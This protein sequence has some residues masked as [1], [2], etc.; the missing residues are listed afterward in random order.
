[1]EQSAP[2]TRD[3]QPVHVNHQGHRLY[4]G[5]FATPE[6][7]EYGQRLA[8]KLLGHVPEE[9]DPNPTISGLSD[10]EAELVAAKVKARLEAHAKRPGRHHRSSALLRLDSATGL[11]GVHPVSRPWRVEIK[12]DH[13]SYSLGTFRCRYEAA[14]AYNLA[15][16]ILHGPDAVLN[17]IPPD[18]TPTLEKTEE[19]RQRVIHQLGVLVPQ[20]QRRSGVCRSG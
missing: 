12:K 1:M 18:E 17:P 15:A 10:E 14:T 20:A 9:L 11:K 3:T 5:T 8:R 2:I 16:E 13:R 7:A 19:I 6:E 4:I